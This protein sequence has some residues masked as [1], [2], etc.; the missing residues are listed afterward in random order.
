MNIRT[1]SLLFTLMG[2]MA[3]WPQESLAQG[4]SKSHGPPPWAPAHGYRAK[5]RQVYFPE[6]NFYFD[7]QKGT[8]IYFNNGKWEVSVKLPTLFAG[9][10]LRQ[11]VQVELE[12]NTDRPQ[13]Y[14]RDHIATYSKPKGNSGNGNKGKSGSGK[15]GHY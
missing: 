11:A 4:A 2:V 14:N 13:L 5:T 12:L 9:I 15:K 6:H 10:N 1:L 8:Y 3:F 7:V